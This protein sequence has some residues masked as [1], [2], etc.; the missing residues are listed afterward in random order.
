MGGGAEKKLPGRQII[1]YRVSTFRGGVVALARISQPPRC[2]AAVQRSR[3]KGPSGWVRGSRPRALRHRRAV[4]AGM[5][6]W[7]PTKFGVPG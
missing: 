7:V 1:V 5:L 6:Q 2:C 3:C 4:L